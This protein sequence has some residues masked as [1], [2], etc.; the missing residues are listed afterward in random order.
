MKRSLFGVVLLAV[1]W[2]TTANAA[3]LFGDIKADGKPLPKGVVVTLQLIGKPDAKGKPVA[4]PIDTTTTDEGGS[5]KFTVK[6]EGKCTLTV[7]YEKQPITIDV[8][9]YKEPTRYDLILE[10]KEGKLTLHRK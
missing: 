8:F 3:R 1:F 7:L 2:S 4:G 10:K 9:S 6:D 5:Y